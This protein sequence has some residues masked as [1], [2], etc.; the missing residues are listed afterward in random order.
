MKKIWNQLVTLAGF[1]WF[2]VLLIALFLLLAFRITGY[3]DPE[4]IKVA[5]GVMLGVALG[6]VADILKRSLD[7]FQKRSNLRRTALALLKTDAENI[8]RSMEGIKD[9]RDHKDSAPKEVREMLETS[10]PI[11]L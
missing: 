11:E 4:T 1:V 5:L 9:A 7:E 6:F 2:P 10:L 3:S 8:F